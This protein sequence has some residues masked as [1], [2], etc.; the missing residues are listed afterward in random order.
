MILLFDDYAQLLK[1]LGAPEFNRRYRHPVLIG[2]GVVGDLEEDGE[3]GNEQTFLAAIDNGGAHRDGALMRRVWIL[4]K[5]DYG[6]P[7]S[8]IRVGRDAA[9]DIVIPDYSI[10]KVHC[11]FQRIDG[12]VILRDLD[13]HNGVVVEG[14]LLQPQRP[15]VVEDEDEV[16]LGRYKFEF[17][18]AGTFVERV[19]NTAYS[20]R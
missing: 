19:R 9:N 1:Q 15:V 6:P 20:L 7:G 11:E 10:S 17:L 12:H 2:V 3:R 8:G 14:K 18:L 5:R 4:R 13:S 16:V